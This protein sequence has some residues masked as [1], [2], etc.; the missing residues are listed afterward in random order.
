M[1]KPVLFS[2]IFIHG[3]VF[4]LLSA[5][6]SFLWWQWAGKPYIFGM[7]PIGGDYFNAL[8]Y[9]KF[10]STHLPLPPTGW[11]PFWNEGSAV[12][13]GYPWFAFYLMYPLTRFFD[14]ATSMEVFSAVSLLLF[15]LASLL[16]FTHVSKNWLLAF[17]LTLIL[18]STKASYYALT[19]GGF[20]VSASAQWYLPIVLLASYKFGET[21]K[22]YYLVLAAIGGGISLLHHA[23]TSLLMVC[24]PTIM[25]LASLPSHQKNIIQ[26]IKPIALFIV[27]TSAIGSMGLY[28]VSLQTFLGSGVDP[29]QSP[30]CWGVYPKH[31][32]VWMTPLAP[33]I[34]IALLGA[35]LI[36]KISYRSIRFSS[37][38]PALSGFAL[39]FLYALFAHLK[40]INGPANVIFPTRVFWAANLFLLLASA[41]LFHTLSKVI[42]KVAL[43]ISIGAAIV[44]G[45]ITYAAPIAI[46]KDFTNTDPIDSYKYTILKYQTNKLHEIVPYWMPLEE[47]NWRF[48][49]FN[50]ALTHWWNVVSQVPSTRGYSDHPVGVHRD[51]QYFLQTAT[52]D[53]KGAN[54]ALIKNR[55]LFL[56]D[57]FGVGFHEN[58]IASYPRSILEDSSIT[59][60]S[61]GVRNSAWFQFS[62]QFTSPIVSPTNGNTVLFVGDDAGYATFIRALAMTN[63]SSK[64]LVPVRGPPDIDRV[65]SEELRTFKAIVAYRFH[66]RNWSKILDYVKK[67]GSALIETG[68]ALNHP[69]G[70]LP[71]IFPMNRL[72]TSQILGTWDPT[73]NSQ[74]PIVSGLTVSRFSSFVFKGKPW[75]LSKTSQDQ[76]RSWAQPL[77]SQGKDVILI[78]GTLNKGKVVWSGFNLPFHTVDKDNLEEAIL[79]KNVLTSLIEE[80]PAQALYTVKRPSP[81]KIFI[82]GE[83][84]RGIYFK[85]NYHP[86]WIAKVNGQRV[87]VYKAGLD[88]MFIPIPKELQD[89]A[90]R[91]SV[92]FVGSVTTWGLFFLT[93]LSLSLSLLYILFPHLFHRTA[94]RL[95]TYLNTKIHRNIKKWINEE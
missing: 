48:D 90:L 24:L 44:I 28:T 33:L 61:L 50:P 35:T 43:I 52:R 86:G 62:P 27:I 84:F 23:P 80:S 49:T 38:S 11:V 45:S 13:G 15:F 68:S 47:T 40:L 88:F 70:R 64:I 31:L 3:A 42:P 30:Q 75:K 55:A 93:L 39:L 2:L 7:Q 19:T 60:N 74:S 91:I 8:T 5:C 56:I 66:G 81:E 36:A 34:F 57:A 22:T 95:T 82:E 4:L 72:E 89:Q 58:S 78:E 6:I 46:H 1:R 87:P 10:F 29:C 17:T 12:I 67:G 65:S 63:L 16:L 59:I 41:H 76:I 21:K 32:M 18:M 85:E 94:H 73:I 77:L 69:K 26:K 54:H 9:A 51:W 92:L 37:F 71:D 14:T 83:H 25:L 53:P 20:I 79:L